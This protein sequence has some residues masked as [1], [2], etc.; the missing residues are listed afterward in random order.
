MGYKKKTGRSL[1][2]DEVQDDGNSRTAGDDGGPR[3]GTGADAYPCRRDAGLAGQAQRI[4]ERQLRL[5]GLGRAVPVV[6]R[7]VQSRR[8]HDIRFLTAG[9]FLWADAPDADGHTVLDFNRAYNP[10]CAF[11]PFATCPLLPPGNRLDATVTAGEKKWR[12]AQH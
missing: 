1:A 4:L 11:T 7:P 12:D 3:R 2:E 8:R 5:A 10:P 6:R 9:R